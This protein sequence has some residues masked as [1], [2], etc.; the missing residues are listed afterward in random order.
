[1]GIL[2]N[3]LSELLARALRGLSFGSVEIVV[4]DGLVVHV[5]RRERLRLARAGHCS[6]ES[7]MRKH[8]LPIGPAGP[9]EVPNR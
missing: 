7:R 3:E 4:H 2:S 9:P 8:N 6:P 5:E 1:M